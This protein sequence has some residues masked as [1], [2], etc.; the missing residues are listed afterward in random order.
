[1]GVD[2]VVSAAVRRSV[3]ALNEAQ[4]QQRTVSDRLATGKA[5]LT[6]RDDP[7]RFFTARALDSRAASVSSLLDDMGKAIQ[8]LKAADDGIKGVSKLLDVAKGKISSAQA[9]SNPQTRAELAA[10]FDGILRQIEGLARDSSFKGKNLLAGSGNTLS[11]S[12]D[13]ENLAKL[14]IP[15][16]DYT[17]AA[18]PGGL[19]VNNATNNW[20]ND[21][22]IDAA[23]TEITAALIRVRRDADGFGSSKALV[24]NR[25][26]FA[27]VIMNTLTNGSERL[28]AADMNA[29]GAKLLALQ[30]RQSLST[31]ALS[32]ANG[33]EQDVMRLFG[34]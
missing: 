32:L 2:L 15:P 3:T 28:T 23:R 12:F 25:Q 21:A 1:M 31:S 27:R 26:D 8:T 11:V 17:D 22:D 29:E 14:E 5:V 33:A 24:E 7:G 18:Y 4:Q 9:E 13:E 10:E 16:V 20:L 30:T 19:A 34:G 6:A